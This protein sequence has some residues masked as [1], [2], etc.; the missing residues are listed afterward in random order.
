MINKELDGLNSSQDS[1]ILTEYLIKS[2]EAQ[3]L[4]DNLVKLSETLDQTEK[5]DPSSNLKKTI[6]NSISLGR[7]QKR[8]KRSWTQ[9][10]LRI[11]KYNLKYAFVFAVGMI[12]GIIGYITFSDTIRYT[13]RSSLIGTLALDEKMEDLKAVDQMEFNNPD[14]NCLLNLKSGEGYLLAELDLKSNT[15]IS[16]KLE[17]DHQNINFA[18]IQNLNDQNV[19]LVVKNNFLEL[20]HIG[21]CKYF[22]LLKDRTI[23]MSIIDIKIFSEK[24]LLTEKT[25]SPEQ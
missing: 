7:Y 23:G 11:P 9:I 17:F 19:D 14:I 3:N 12:L 24:T 22:I 20:N 2:A 18:A 8:E 4:Y 13:D 6:L 5:I 21:E 16:I 1:A 15:L 10:V 25:L